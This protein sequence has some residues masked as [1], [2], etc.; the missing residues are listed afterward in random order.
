MEQSPA[1][2]RRLLAEPSWD[3]T[4]HWLEGTPGSIWEVLLCLHA[5]RENPNNNCYLE[6]PDNL[7]SS[8]QTHRG[9]RWLRTHTYTHSDSEVSRCPETGQMKRLCSLRFY[10]LCSAW[11]KIHMCIFLV[12]TECNHV[13]S[14]SD[15]S[16]QSEDTFWKPSW[17]QAVIERSGSVLLCGFTFVFVIRQDHISWYWLTKNLIQYMQLRLPISPDFSLTSRKEE[18]HLDSV[19]VHVCHPSSKTM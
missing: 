8:R 4:S 9:A 13:V 18:K 11:H 2:P 12:G 15:E 3:L 5:S 14:L 7:Q 17:L 19:F 10:A 16:F 6:Q 1:P